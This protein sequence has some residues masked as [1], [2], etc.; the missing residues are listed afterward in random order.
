MLRQGGQSTSVTNGGR[1][2]VHTTFDDGSEMVD[3]SDW[4]ETRPRDV[5]AALT[6]RTTLSKNMTKSHSSC[7]VRSTACS[8]AANYPK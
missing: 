8:L 3:S 2:K 4:D 1:K 7:S 5:P 6:R